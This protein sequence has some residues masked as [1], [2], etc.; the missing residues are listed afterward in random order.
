[1]VQDNYHIK[2]SIFLSEIRIEFTIPFLFSFSTAH[3][4]PLKLREDNVFLIV[5][6]NTRQILTFTDCTNDFKKGTSAKMDISC[7]FSKDFE[8]FNLVDIQ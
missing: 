8:G 7:W 5:F 4:L 3:I 1:M 2:V 6:Y